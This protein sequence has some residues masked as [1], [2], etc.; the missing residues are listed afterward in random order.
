MNFVHIE[1]TLDWKTRTKLTHIRSNND[2]NERLGCERKQ[3]CVQ[4]KKKR[5][6]LNIDRRQNWPTMMTGLGR[7]TGWRSS[8]LQSHLCTWPNNICK[9]KPSIGTC[10]TQNYAHLTQ[11]ENEHYTPCVEYSKI[12]I[13][14]IGRT[15][16][17]I[18]K[19]YVVFNGAN[20]DT[21]FYFRKKGARRHALGAP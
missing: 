8:Q 18:D 19:V 6:R 21:G 15:R 11:H 14:R 20:H 4:C 16:F 3:L 9:G 10:T 13:C 17:H 7:S 2:D 1:S 5:E 12:S